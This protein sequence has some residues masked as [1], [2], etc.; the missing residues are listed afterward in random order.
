MDLGFVLKCFRQAHQTREDSWL[1]LAVYV[2]KYTKLSL[3]IVCNAIFQL[4]SCCVLELFAIKS[5]S[6]PKSRGKF[7]FVAAKF[8]TKFHK[9][10]SPLNMW[11]SLV[12]ISQV[13]SEI[14]R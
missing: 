4:T 12:T 9:S 7:M 11:Q 10:G 2:Q 6:C 8:L 13:T 3:S 14:R 5:Q 1:F